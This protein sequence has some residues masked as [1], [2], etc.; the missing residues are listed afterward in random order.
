VTLTKLRST[1]AS[2]ELFASKS[3]LGR[4]GKVIDLQFL[5]A[6][7]DRCRGRGCVGRQPARNDDAVDEAGKR[8]NAADEEGCYG[9]PVGSELRRVAVNAVEV[10]HIGYGNVAAS[11]DVVAIGQNGLVDIDVAD[12]IVRNVL[13]HENACHGTEENGVATE[14]SKEL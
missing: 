3:L 13:S 10:V 7:R 14:E 11:D 12:G 8:G 9:A 6:Q 2:S 5:A 1:L 4:G